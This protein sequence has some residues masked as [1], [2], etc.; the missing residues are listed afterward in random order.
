MD[1][2]RQAVP[3]P[4]PETIGPGRRDHGAVV[5]TQDGRGIDHLDAPLRAFF[6]HP[7]AQA[8]VAGHPARD[9]YGIGA[10]GQSRGQRLVDQDV[11]DGF[12]EGGGDMR[13]VAVYLVF[14][15]FRQVQAHRVLER[16]LQAARERAKLLGETCFHNGLEEDD[17]FW[18]KGMNRWGGGAGYV[19]FILDMN[20]SWFSAN[21]ELS[22][23]VRA[24]VRRE[25]KHAM[26]E[27]AGM[28]ED[29]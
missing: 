29:E 7:L 25:W 2:K 12:L 16:A 9:Q 26:Q 23:N 8:A 6:S 17:P 27:L 24:M 5:R 14:G 13:L 18:V 10:H 15:S 4:C 22:E 28:L 19:D 21:R 3:L 1:G 20:R 11:Y